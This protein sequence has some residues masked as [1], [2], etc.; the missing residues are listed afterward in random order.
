MGRADRSR[1]RYIIRG[2][3][4]VPRA[5][6]SIV[7]LVTIV[8]GSLAL[9]P[10]ASACSCTPIG[11]VHQVINFTKAVF[12]G[13]TLRVV[14]TARSRV[15]TFEVTETFKQRSPGMDR[16]NVHTPP[17]EGSCG[18][19]FTV[20]AVYLVYAD[21]TSAGGLGSHYCSRTRLASRASAD[22]AFLRALPPALK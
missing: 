2:M 20:G 22:L 5:L 12:V 16:V 4:K 9:P 21:E 19:D 17:D 10:S 13:R 1:L 15:V 18:I 14:K 11:E 6:P 3:P 7:A 8:L